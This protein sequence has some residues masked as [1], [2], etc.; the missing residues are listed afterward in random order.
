MPPRIYSLRNRFRMPGSGCACWT[1]GR[2]LG[3]EPWYG[4]TCGQCC[5]TK[6]RAYRIDLRQAIRAEDEEEKCSLILLGARLGYH[7]MEEFQDVMKE[8]S[9]TRRA[10][11]IAKVRIGDT[12][13][14]KNAEKRY[15]V[16]AVN[17]KRTTQRCC[18]Q[19]YLRHVDRN[20]EMRYDPVADRVSVLRERSSYQR[21]TR[22]S[23]SV[24]ATEVD[25]SVDEED[26][27]VEEEYD[28]GDEKGEPMHL[29]VFEKDEAEIAGHDQDQELEVKVMTARGM[30][31]V[32]CTDETTFGEVW[33]KMQEW[34]PEYVMERQD[35][36]NPSMVYQ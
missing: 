5:D 4:G 10:D 6:I 8:Y 14:K 9:E 29:H 20:A 34:S 35:G 3:P 30:C 16:P 21:T 23:S 1:C 13:R 22:A 27:E 7:Y 17:F 32:P 24:A 19:L 28:S 12:K 2:L 15:L 18:L 11:E 36:A 33:Q 31:T 25:D 26:D